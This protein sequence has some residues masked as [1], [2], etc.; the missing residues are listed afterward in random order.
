MAGVRRQ[1]VSLRLGLTLFLF[2]SVGCAQHKQSSIKNT[3]SAECVQCD[4]LVADIANKDVL[5]DWQGGAL[6]PLLQYSAK[7]A[8]AILAMN[9]TCIEAL[10]KVLK[11]DTKIQISHVLLTMILGSFQFGMPDVQK[12]FNELTVDFANPSAPSVKPEE[13]ERIEKL[14]Q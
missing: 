1:A 7:S 6:M 13:K 2:F 12:Q 8:K 5:W 4:S 14:W 9:Y 10:N 11:D 3:Y